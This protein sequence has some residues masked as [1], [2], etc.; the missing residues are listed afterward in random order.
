VSS[1]PVEEV[2]RAI[3]RTLAGYQCTHDN[4]VGDVGGRQSWC[5]ECIAEAYIPA[6]RAAVDAERAE[7][8]EMRAALEPFAALAE[9]EDEAAKAAGCKPPSDSLLLS[10]ALRHCRKARKAL[11]P[12]GVD[13]DERKQ[14]RDL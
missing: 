3:A 8:S 14:G 6:L 5:V 2:A 9:D 4:N 7:A 13:V 11:L 10:I 1:R 12:R